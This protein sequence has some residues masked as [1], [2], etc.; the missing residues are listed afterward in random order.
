MPSPKKTTQKKDTVTK[1]NGLLLFFNYF[2]LIFLGAGIAAGF[3]PTRI[4]KDLDKITWTY[5]ATLTAV[6]LTWVFLFLNRKAVSEVLAE[7]F[8]SSLKKPM[9]LC[10]FT[11]KLKNAVPPKYILA[12][13][14]LI[15]AAFLIFS[16]RLDGLDF[17]D[18]EFLVLKAAKG[19][20]ETGTYVSWDFIKNAPSHKEYTRAWPHTI[21]VAQSFKLFGVSEWS[22]RLVS[23]VSGCVFIGISFF[24][25]AYFT[26]NF[27]FSLFVSIVFL[28]NPD[29][30]RYWRYSRMYAL[31]LPT[32]CIWAFL[33]HKA[34][35]G[36]PRKKENESPK[37]SLIADCLN[38]NWLYAG[39]SFIVLYFAYHIHIN[40]MVLPLAAIIYL[41]IV[42]VMEKKRKYTLRLITI[43][44]ASLIIFPFIPEKVFTNLT[45]YMLFFKAYNPIYFQLIVQRPFYSLISLS[46][47]TGS[48]ILLLYMPSEQLR[49]KILFCIIIVLT[50]IVFFVYFANFSGNHYRFI[51][52]TVP[53]AILLVCF[54]YFI[55][56]KTFR[57]RFIL[58]AGV[59]MLLLAQAGNFFKLQNALYHG[60]LLQPVPSVAYQTVKDHLNPKDVIFIQGLKDY[61]MAGIPP[62]TPIISLGY[63]KQGTSGPSSYRFEQFFNDLVTNRQGWVIWEKY[64]ERHVDPKVAAYV[65]TLFKK[66]HG[67]GVDDTEVEVFYFDESMIKKPNFK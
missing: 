67:Q 31:L 21:L 19:Y 15:I 38:F 36:F 35:E 26:Q 40:S 53:F 17:W 45:H 37:Q 48:V 51:S 58:V 18:D 10:S 32:F 47:L 23:A 54:V 3:L 57:N 49:R 42:A 41:L 39:L 16:F 9:A 44:I 66:Y 62:N 13:C 5:P 8:S 28:L 65:K 50:T 64:K 60:A 27:L 4:L 46:L 30:M 59:A 63:V 12:V 1:E 43:G 29:F 22:T 20:Q 55:I 7:F 25:C 34:T 6:F 14:I 24:V 11:E 33:V 56:L 2:Y 52:H 61:Y